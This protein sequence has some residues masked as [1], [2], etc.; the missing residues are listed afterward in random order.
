MGG[1]SNFLSAHGTGRNLPY[2]LAL[3]PVPTSST[4]LIE[5]KTMRTNDG[6]I[7]SGMAA[8]GT[9]LSLCISQNRKRKARARLSV[10]PWNFLSLSAVDCRELAL[11]LM[12]ASEI[13]TESTKDKHSCH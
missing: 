7:V 10:G 8:D 4:A 1:K 9:S 3:P 13:L 5:R 12:E 11:Y 2:T 6:E